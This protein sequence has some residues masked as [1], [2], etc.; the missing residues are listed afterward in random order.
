MSLGDEQYVSVTTYRRDGTPVSTPVWVAAD[1]GDLVFW[2]VTSS[3]KVKRIRNNPAV[4]VAPCDLRGNL[5]GEAVR[6]TATILSAEE[7][8]RVRGLLRRK[9]GL[10]GRITL[11]GS[12]LRRGSTGTV[13]V[14]I[15]DI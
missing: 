10:V 8:E 6:G 15:T 9:Y 12:K 11:L 13:G 2:T 4:T 5:K 3:A 7:T 14:R 1:G